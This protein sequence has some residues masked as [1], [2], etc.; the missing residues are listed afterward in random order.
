MNG[1]S[2][3]NISPVWPSIP[4][5]NVHYGFFFPPSKI[6]S[7]ISEHTIIFWSLTN[8]FRRNPLPI[9]LCELQVNSLCS[10][11]WRT[12][13]CRAARAF[14]LH[15]IPPDTLNRVMTWCHVDGKTYQ[16]LPIVLWAAPLS[17][18]SVI[19]THICWRTGDGPP[20]SAPQRR[21][22]LY[23]IIITTHRWRHTRLVV[24][25]A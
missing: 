1:H 12:Q 6:L 19:S 11:I 22:L 24:K 17:N 3:L 20:S 7:A 5:V 25:T 21:L 16:T 15:D 8:A 13:V 14:D 18:I 23:Q 4:K 9:W 10:V 2:W